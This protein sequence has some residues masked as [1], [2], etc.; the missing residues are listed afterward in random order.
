MLFAG[1]KLF[2]GGENLGVGKVSA[3]AYWKW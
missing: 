2:I 1:L 3:V